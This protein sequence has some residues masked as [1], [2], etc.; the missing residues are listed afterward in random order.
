MLTC[1][2]ANARKGKSKCT[3]EFY[4]GMKREHEFRIAMYHHFLVSVSVLNI[5]F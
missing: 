3:D 2:Q 5:N 4:H 1:S